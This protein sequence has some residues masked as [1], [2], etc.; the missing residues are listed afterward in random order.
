VGG[1]GRAGGAGLGW[2]AGGGWVGWAA[3]EGLGLG[4][5]PRWAEVLTAVVD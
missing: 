3:A 5:Q 1:G 2:G 4:D